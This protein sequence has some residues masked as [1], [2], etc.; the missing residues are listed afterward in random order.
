MADELFPP[1]PQNPENSLPQDPAAPRRWPAARRPQSSCRAAAPRSST[2]STSRTRCGAAI[3]TTPC[4]SSSAAPCPTSATASSPSIAASSTACRRWACSS[5]RS[6]PSPPRS[7][8]TSWATTIPTATPPSTTPWSASRSPSRLR[9]PMVDGQG[10][11]GSVDGDP[12]AAM[13]Y[14]ESRLTRIAGEMLA[15]IDSDTVDFA[16]NYDESSARAHRPARAHPQP[17]RQRQLRHRRRHGHQHPAAQPHR[18]R[19]R[20]HRAPRQSRRRRRSSDLDLCLDH[21]L[22]PDFPTGGYIFGKTNIPGAYKTGRGR[23]IMR[24]K[25]AIE[26][27][28]GGRQAIIV[29]EIPYQVNKAKLIERIADLVN[30]GIITDI[31]RDE[32]RDESDRDGMR[33]VIGLK[34]GAEHQIVLNQLHKHTQMQESFSM[35]FLAVHNN[36]P[37]EL[38]LDAAIRAFLEHRMEVVR[39]RTAFLLAKARDREH[40]LSATRS[41][42]TTSTRSSRSSASL[43]RAPT[44][45]KISSPTSPAK[46]SPS[47]APNS[48]ASRSTP[49]STPS[50]LPTFPPTPPASPPSSSRSSR[51]T[52][53]SNCSSTAS[54]SSPSTSC[55]TNSAPSATPSP[56]TNPSSPRKPSSAKSSSRSS[57]KSATSTATPAAPRSST[58]PPS[59]ASKTSSPT[60][61]SPSPSP[62]PATSSARPSPSTAS[63]GAAAP[64]V[65]A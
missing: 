58:R 5:T 28:S 40:I 1:D 35:I 50:T 33:I 44:P 23:F 2:P 42:S 21:V 31:A 55:S 51:S 6:T 11:F 34:R 37:K 8:A 43:P 45:A 65:S 7:S 10:N 12:P 3:S 47:A 56:S 63:S 57:P 20:L 9:Y 36:Q 29:T 19:Q 60:S 48:P 4:R 14:T 41:P 38:P 59:S 30:D 53:S 54:P 49:P 61:R 24:A 25:C 13:R 15:D 64:A 22:G 16:P 26:N 62:T 27:I 52:P 32:F 39:R 18:S 46:T 17:P